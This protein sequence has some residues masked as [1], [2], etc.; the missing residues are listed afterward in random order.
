MTTMKVDAAVRWNNGKVFFFFGGQYVRFDFP[1]DQTDPGY[2]KPIGPETWPG[3][4]FT[5]GID[6][7]LLWKDGKMFLFKGSQYIRFDIMTDKVDPGYPKPI[8][9]NWPGLPFTDGIDSAV[10]WNNG[11]K[12]FFFKGDQYVR[13]DVDADKVDEGYPKKIDDNTWPGLSFTKHIDALV[14]GDNGKLFVF[15]GDQYVR[16]DITTDKQ[17][18]GYPKPI[19]GNW[20]GLVEC[21]TKG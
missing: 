14:M 16:F 4:P 9:G 8:A 11:K 21:L 10:L 5:H 18:P 20:P 6:A 1:S 2:P 13:F 19:A 15:Q 7:A 3:V 17:D 12:V